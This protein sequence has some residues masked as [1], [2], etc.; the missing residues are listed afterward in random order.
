MTACQQPGCTGTI[1]DGYCDVCG[2]PP[3]STPAFAPA[4]AGPAI[5]QPTRTTEPQEEL[6]AAQP[7]GAIST[8]T[9]GSSRLGSTA[10]GSSRL[11]AAGSK[12]TKRVHSDSSRLRSARLGA[13]LTRVPPAPEIDASRAIMKNPQI[14][15]DKR[16][17]SNCGSPV[18]RSRDGQA[19]RAEGFCPKCGNAY[20]FTP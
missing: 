18:G 11:T 6:P 5:R 20:S 19:G 14:P 8:R 10:L 16:F 15:E 7:A 2:S 9:R 3:S 12:I 4:A 13:G 1:V 17:C